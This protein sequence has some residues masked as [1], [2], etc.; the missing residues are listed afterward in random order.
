LAPKKLQWHDFL[1]LNLNWLEL[2][3]PGWGWKG[4]LELAGSSPAA[5]SEVPNRLFVCL[6]ELAF[7]LFLEV[8][9]SILVLKSQ[10]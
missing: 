8:A 3:H 7:E 4:R 9:A 5:G 2:S 1:N 6:F 10:R